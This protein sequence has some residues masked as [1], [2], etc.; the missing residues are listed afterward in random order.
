[1]N[2]TFLGNTF[3]KFFKAGKSVAD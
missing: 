3:C 1:M 2:N